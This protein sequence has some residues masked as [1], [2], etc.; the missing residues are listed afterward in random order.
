MTNIPMPPLQ[1]QPLLKLG[2]TLP[3]ESAVEYAPVFL[4]FNL[5]PEVLLTSDSVLNRDDNLIEEINEICKGCGGCTVHAPFISMFWDNVD[6]EMQK[7]TEEVLMGSAE[8]SSTLKADSAVIHTNFDPR[9]GE[10]IDQWLSK[11][12]KGLA[13]VTEYY[14]SLGVRPLIENVRESTPEMLLKIRAELWDDTGICIDPGHAA[15]ISEVSAPEWFKAVK[16]HLCEIHLH[17]NYKDYDA[18]LP[19]SKGNGW[20]PEKDLKNLIKEGYSFFPVMEPKD[21]ETAMINIKTLT[22]WGLR[23]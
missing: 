2:C 10:T 6:S 4:K 15:V 19:L 7:R 16:P 14:A 3:F 8:L 22:E 17:N 23:V 9:T 21:K 1:E 12:V 20:D 18:H 11:K 13:K 5:R